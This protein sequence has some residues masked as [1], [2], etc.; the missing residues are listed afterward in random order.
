[1]KQIVKKLKKIQKFAQENEL[2]GELSF[3]VPQSILGQGLTNL[4]VIK[5]WHEFLEGLSEEGFEVYGNKIYVSQK[6]TVRLILD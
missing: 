2:N 5:G 1:M 6:L 4:E 3:E